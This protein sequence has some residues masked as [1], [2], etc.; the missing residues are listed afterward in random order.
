MHRHFNGTLHLFGTYGIDAE[1]WGP[2]EDML[3]ALGLDYRVVWMGDA[4]ESEAFIKSRLSASLPIFF[5][6]WD[7]H[8]LIDEYKLSR[9]QLPTYAEDLYLQGKTDF[10]TEVLEKVGLIGSH[11]P[12]AACHVTTHAVGRCSR[13]AYRNSLPTSMHSIFAS[14]STTPCSDRLCGRWILRDCP[15]SRRRASG[16]GAR[17]MPKGGSDGCNPISRAPS[18]LISLMKTLVSFAQKARAL[19]GTWSRNARSAQLVRSLTCVHVHLLLLAYC[20]LPPSSGRCCIS[21]VCACRRR[22]FP[23]Q[24]GAVWL[25]QL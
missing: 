6:L 1:T 15:C 17:P 11:R 16:F 24:G 8:P 7:P 19:W 21:C 22:L 4:E 18:A 12:D 13:L 3:K 14:E 9:I 23:E 5:Y 25:H 2:Q 20:D 10:P